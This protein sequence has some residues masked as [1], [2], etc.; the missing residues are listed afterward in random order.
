MEQTWF[1][2]HSKYNIQQI[3]F[4]DLNLTPSEIEKKM[5]KECIEL[6]SEEGKT[7]GFTSEY[8]TSLSFL[9]RW[10]T[11]KHNILEIAF[12]EVHNKNRHI[13][14]NFL[15]NLTKKFDLIYV[16]TPCRTM[17]WLGWKYE[18]TYIENSPNEY[19]WNKNLIHY[20]KRNRF[21]SYLKEYKKNTIYNKQF[22]MW[23]GQEIDKIRLETKKRIFSD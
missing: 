7:I 9:R 13:I 2:P 11:K 6:D 15:K 8:F 3:W 16:N 19:V 21:M 23:F 5:K 17:F 22:M 18:I 12:I 14:S 1:K 4:N 20:H 10:K